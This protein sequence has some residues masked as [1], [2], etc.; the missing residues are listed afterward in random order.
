MGMWNWSA[1]L[2]NKAWAEGKQ[3]IAVTRCGRA[4]GEGNG[5]GGGYRAQSGWVEGA[6][7]GTSKTRLFG[8]GSD[9]EYFSVQTI[10]KSYSLPFIY[11]TVT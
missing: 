2:E 1:S 7:E 6:K 9:L 3:S 5:G 8:Y 11:Y 10:S 4:E